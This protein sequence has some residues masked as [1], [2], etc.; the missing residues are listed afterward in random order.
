MIPTY[1]GLLA[2]QVNFTS[3]RKKKKQTDVKRTRILG[4]LAPLGGFA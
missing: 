4:L 3:E 1:L 2:S